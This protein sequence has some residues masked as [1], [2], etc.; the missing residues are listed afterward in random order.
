MPFYRSKPSNL[1]LVSAIIITAAG[2][3]IPL[4]VLDSFFGF[5]LPP[6]SFFGVLVGLVIGYVLLV[7]LGKIG[8][9]RKYS[10]FIRNEKSTII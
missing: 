3:L 10:S 5:V 9:Y 4:T 2:I 7:E 6:L 8:F 1:L